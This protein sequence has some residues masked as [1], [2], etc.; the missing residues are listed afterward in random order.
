VLRID[1]GNREDGEEISC[2]V[3]IEIKV[4]YFLSHVA[5]NLKVSLIDKSLRRVAVNYRNV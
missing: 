2:S 5:I 3:I 4:F 1:G